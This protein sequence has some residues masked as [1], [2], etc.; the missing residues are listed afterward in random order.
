[1]QAPT[2]RAQALNPS[3]NPRPPKSP[4]PDPTDEPP[5]SQLPSQPRTRY[6]C[7]L[8]YCAHLEVYD[9]QYSSRSRYKVLLHAYHGHPLLSRT[10]DDEVLDMIP[11][12]FCISSKHAPIRWVSRRPDPQIGRHAPERWLVSF[13]T[14]D[15][16]AVERTRLGS[17]QL[18]LRTFIRAEI[19]QRFGP[20]W[21]REA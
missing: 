12:G 3:Q 18:E 20:E 15:C 14:M 11:N 6:V 16:R 8:P 4:V 1:M 2:T 21:N 7:H 17:I 5:A 10:P 9:I 19:D 13:G